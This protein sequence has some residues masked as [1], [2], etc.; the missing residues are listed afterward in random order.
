MSTNIKLCSLCNIN[1]ALP[2]RNTFYCNICFSNKFIENFRYK[3]NEF[4]DQKNLIVFNGSISSSVLFYLLQSNIN[5]EVINNF[6]FISN[7][8]M[9]YININI[10]KYLF[11]EIPKNIKYW[12]K[13][14]N[15]VK[16]IEP[17]SLNKRIKVLYES[18]G[19]DKINWF[20]KLRPFENIIDEEI[21]RFFHFYENEIYSPVQYVSFSLNNN[22]LF[23]IE[24]WN[25]YYKKSNNS[26]ILL[27]KYLKK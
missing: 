9:P 2:M 11:N 20:G 5:K 13:K 19:F 8:D 3:I 22:N 15:C 21:K 27:S 12:L 23:F 10:E 7:I 18:K 1:I 26:S 16:I 14:Y 25:K 4:F 6:I 17:D 24:N